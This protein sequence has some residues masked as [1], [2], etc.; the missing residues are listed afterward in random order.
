MSE[1]R[2]LSEEAR[3]D[4]A[5]ALKKDRRAV[6]QG[7]QGA[8]AAIDL[9]RMSQGVAHGVRSQVDSVAGRLYEPRHRV[10][11]DARSIDKEL[12]PGSETDQRLP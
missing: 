6:R 9:G 5:D 12:W 8:L 10:G 7:D 2:A 11:I 1:D 4:M 3:V